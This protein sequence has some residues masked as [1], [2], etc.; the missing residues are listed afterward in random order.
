MEK[1]LKSSLSSLVFCILG[2]AILYIFFDKDITELHFYEKNI[3]VLID[4]FFAIFVVLAFGIVLVASSVGFVG[5]DKNITI[6]HGKDNGYYFPAFGFICVVT[7][8]LVTGCF[9]LFFSSHAHNAI[10]TSAVLG[11]NIIAA[12]MAAI[13]IALTVLFGSEKT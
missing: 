12:G 8:L 13:F 9:L 5:E 2:L 1:I 7:G 4:G 11:A 3:F 6:K 10:K